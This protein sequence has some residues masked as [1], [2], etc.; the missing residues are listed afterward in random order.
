[1]TSVARRLTGS[2]FFAGTVVLA[3]C[4]SATIGDPTVF[5]IE[6]THW[7]D[8]PSRELVAGLLVGLDRHPWLIVLTRRPGG[9]GFVPP[10]MP[11]V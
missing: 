5:V 2:I 7:M 9:D 8:E 6:D 10:E 4:A 11:A 3:G 1:M